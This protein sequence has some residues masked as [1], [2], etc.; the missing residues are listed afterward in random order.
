M[1]TFFFLISSNVCVL[2]YSHF[3]LKG[4]Q[5]PI[6]TE[7][8]GIGRGL[9][10]MTGVLNGAGYAVCVSVWSASH[11]T[12]LTSTSIRFSV[13]LI[14]NVVLSYRVVLGRHHI[15]RFHTTSHRRT[16]RCSC[17]TR[18]SRCSTYPN[19]TKSRL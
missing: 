13:D 7:E 3:D 5:V 17:E 14:S 18:K 15:C 11:I 4:K 12:L 16:V 9:Q 2:Q 19:A 6:W 10:P 1:P 8:Q